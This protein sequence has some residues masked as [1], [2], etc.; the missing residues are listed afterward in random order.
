M[1]KISSP[2]LNKKHI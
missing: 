1:E 2:F